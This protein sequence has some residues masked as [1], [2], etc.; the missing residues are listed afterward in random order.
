MKTIFPILFLLCVSRFASSQ[1][2][3]DTNNSVMNLKDGVLVVR[4]RTQTNKINKL[5]EWMAGETPGTP[6]YQRLEDQI[7]E[8]KTEVAS[9]NRIVR[10]AFGDLYQYSD[11]LFFFDTLANALK[12]GKTSGIFL[13]ENMEVDPALKLGDRFYLVAGV[14]SIPSS[15]AASSQEQIII[16]DRNYNL[17][18]DPFPGYSRKFS[19]LSLFKSF[20]LT[21][22]E[23]LRF[24]T[25][26]SV[27]WLNRK[28]TRYSGRLR[29]S[30]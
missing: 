20:F 5:K 13:N 19:I 12:E 1:S 25:R 21:G 16:Y 30:G 29:N 2:P 28:F 17:M 15:E 23:L 3:T 14:G 22:E 6:V 24:K 9:E 27:E 10:K 18:T 26:E 7:E 11:V 4:L 8:V